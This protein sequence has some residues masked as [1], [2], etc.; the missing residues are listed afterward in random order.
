MRDAERVLAIRLDGHPLEGGADVPGL[1]QLD[2]KIDRLHRRVQLLRQR[3]GLQADPRHRRAVF[4]E[5]GNQRLRL[6]QDLRFP[7]DAPRSIDNADAG[8]FRRHVQSG[9]LF[10]GRPSVMLGARESTTPLIETIILRDDHLAAKS[11]S[12]G[13]LDAGPLPHLICF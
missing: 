5:S 2:R 4:A 3:P 1:E 8:A 11:G 10:H 12:T 6:A 7:Q 9:I 13:S